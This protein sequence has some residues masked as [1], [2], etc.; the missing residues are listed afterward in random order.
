MA[1]IEIDLKNNLS[2]ILLFDRKYMFC[3]FSQNM[4]SVVWIPTRADEFAK[5]GICLFFYIKGGVIG[6]LCPKRVRLAKLLKL[7]T[8]PILSIEFPLCYVLI[9]SSSLIWINNNLSLGLKKN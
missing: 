7:S 4:R 1:Q 6:T 5:N 3:D 9:N 2:C 8:Q